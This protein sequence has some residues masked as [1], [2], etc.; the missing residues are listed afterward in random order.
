MDFDILFAPSRHSVTLKAGH[1]FPANEWPTWAVT[2]MWAPEIHYVNN[3]YHVYYSARNR[4]NSQLAIGCAISV[5]CDNPLGPYRDNGNPILEHPLG[6]IDV[7]WFRD[8]K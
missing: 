8:P 2:D 1:V 4:A 3:C 5:E 7:H 6:V